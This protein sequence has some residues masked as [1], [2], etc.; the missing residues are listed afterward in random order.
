MV[1]S[2][3]GPLHTGRRG[4]YDKHRHWI[5]LPELLPDDERVL[6]DTAPDP[7]S[8][9][10]KCRCRDCCARAAARLRG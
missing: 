2:K 7:D 4:G 10:V 9:A 5:D 1:Y 8:H 3:S 6:P